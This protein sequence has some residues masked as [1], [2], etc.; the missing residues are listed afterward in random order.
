MV[1]VALQVGRAHVNVRV[2]IGPHRRTKGCCGK[3]HVLAPKDGHVGIGP[4][5]VSTVFVMVL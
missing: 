4:R 1:N 5:A 2:V 3:C